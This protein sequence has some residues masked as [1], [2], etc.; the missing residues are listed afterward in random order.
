[1]RLRV[2]L[3]AIG[4]AQLF[5][6][7]AFSASAGEKPAA[8]IV[9]Q[10][11]HTSG[12]T[13]VALSPD[14]RLALSASKDNT[15]K[16]WDAATGRE[17]RSF[18]GHTGVVNAAAISPDGKTALS[19]SWDKTLRLWDLETG[20][21][22]RT[23]AGHTGAVTSVAFSRD[24]RL[25]ISGSY[26]RT[27]KLWEVASGRELRT[28]TG[29]RSL[30]EAVALSPDGKLALSGSGDNTA[31][32]PELKLWDVESGRELQN[33]TGHKYR[34]TSVA[35]SPDGTLALSGSA[36]S[37][38]KL[39]DL[40][41]GREI[42]TFTGH[43][44]GISSAAFSPDGKLAL[45]ASTDGTIKLWNAESGRELRT[46]TG[47][48]GWVTSATFSPDG[49]QVLSGS[50]DKTLRLWDAGTGREL[51]SFTRQT[52]IVNA[53]AV[54]P[55]GTS[56]LAGGWDRT[57]KLWDL[58]S[59]RLLRTLRGHTDVITSVAFSPD[60]R[61]ALSGSRDSTMRLWEAA[62]GRE[63][64]SFSGHGG[65]GW[66]LSV[67]FSPDGRLAISGGVDRTLKLW[68]VASGSELGTF[69][70]H[71]G[72]INAIAFSPDG[73]FVLSGSGS[74]LAFQVNGKTVEVRSELKL[75]ELASGRELH[76][77]TG[78]GAAI[79]SLAFSAD[80]R[81]VLSGSSDRTLKLWDAASGRELRSFSGHTEPVLS[82]ALSPDG[83]RALSGSLDR[84]LK[85]WDVESGRELA[86]YAGHGSAA[87][88]A[89]F[90]PDGKEVLSGSEDGTV[91]I[92]NAE[93]LSGAGE[94]KS[95][96]ALAT[97]IASASGG[98]L[99]ITPAGFFSTSA[100][101]TGMLHA[102]RGLEA[103][104]I[105]QVHQSLFNPDLVRDSLAGDPDGEVKRA[106]EVLNLDKV[107]ASGPA[108]EV[109]IA[110]HPSES[111][112][113]TGLVTLAARIKDRG[114]GIGR[115][116][117]RVNGLT[118][119]VMRAPEG[120]APD[121]Q[122]QQ[123]L[124]LDPGENAIEAVAYNARNLLASVPAQTSIAYISPADALKPKLHILAIGIDAYVDK[125]WTPPGTSGRVY[126]PPLS[127][128]VADA[129]AIA[130]ELQKAG[131]GLYSEVRV[132]TALDAE[133]TAAGL[134]DI[135]R[136]FAAGIDP[137]DTFVLFAA[138]HGYS[139]G[140]R[141]Y[142]IPQDYQGGNNPEALKA[143]AIGQERLQDWIAN[144]IKA[145]KAIILL[146]T[147]ESGALTNGYAHSRVDAPASE[148]AVGRL[149]EATGRPVLT[150]AAAG[151]EALEITKLGHGV[152]TS[153]L[154]D[155]LHH[156]DTNGNGL[157]EVSELAAHV[158][159]LV[160]KLVAGGEGRSAV[161]AR[162]PEGGESQSARFGTTGGDFAL[163][164]RLP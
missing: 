135:V 73:R 1:M 61:L 155:A 109:E 97:L 156:G 134:D 159:D 92:W 21:E 98:W 117:W 24:G 143:R 153:A 15:L 122:V 118:V 106:A 84:T 40:A 142:L 67:A 151:Q 36:D 108:P 94:A 35:F 105:G 16:L 140:G 125:G 8:Q 87:V 126:F 86:T 10:L 75:W 149:H 79:R 128:A 146:D 104:T 77:F 18:A 7:E 19:G 85:L 90:S 28:F 154:I 27:I 72:Q 66:V 119:G 115:I 50:D 26:D 157:I 132:K 51:R 148:A 102:V 69:S 145:K 49:R 44:L 152:F 127:L 96:T 116:E 162:G 164:A 14:G 91:R 110:S 33:F 100:G 133:A 12:V 81:L 158:Q 68:D 144:R 58:A 114:K 136:E 52:E 56:V 39:W 64:R 113:D 9:V 25:A 30:I 60:G 124:A 93:H 130:A 88:S 80:G 129:K 150:A 112:S 138:A 63:L 163:V 46:L 47:H 20:R 76:S 99:A 22:V 42:R 48:K 161:A 139:E 45:S 41:S 95:G 141:F 160:P 107:L 34:V 83:R 6:A 120:A 43:S 62:S 5:C 123:T 3:F 78:H 23:Y 2:F 29:H 13:S 38:L 147:C 89:A 71:H 74:D 11:G 54:S 101:E 111:Q 59:G 32:N 37:T 103:A 65:L 57:L 17:L 70:G 121:Y 53:I 31:S 82:V 137:R 4:I 55:D 131:A